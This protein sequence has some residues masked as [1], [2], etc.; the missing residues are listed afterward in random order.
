MPNVSKNINKNKKH[1]EQISAKLDLKKEKYMTRNA[2]HRRN[3]HNKNKTQNQ[4]IHF[5]NKRTW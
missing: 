4:E 5:E 3:Y 2:K 1:K